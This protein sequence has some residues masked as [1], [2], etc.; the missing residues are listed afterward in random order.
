MSKM[1]K[2]EIPGSSVTHKKLELQYYY[3]ICSTGEC[4]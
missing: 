4:K 1:L 3:K 2:S